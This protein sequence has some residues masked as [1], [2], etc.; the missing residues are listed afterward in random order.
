[1]RRSNAQTLGEV[2]QEYIKTLKLQGK[3]DEVKIHDHW[4]E[5]LGLTIANATKEVRLHNNVLF[6]YMKSSI[7]R[8]ELNMMRT[9]IA[10]AL[11]ERMGKELITE[12]II[13]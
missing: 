7:I 4:N 5:M 10:K 1:M 12:I 2:L 13:R 6:V 9:S 11:N 8:S 3:L